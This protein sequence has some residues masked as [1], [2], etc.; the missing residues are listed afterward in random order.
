MSYPAIQGA[1]L[2]T[3]LSIRF[4]LHEDGNMLLLYN[5]Q[6]VFPNRGDFISLAV[7]EGKLEFR[8]DLGY[9]A[10]VIQSKNN[11]TTGHWHT[12]VAERFYRDGSMILDSEPAVKEKAPCCSVGLNLALPLYIGGLP[13]MTADDKKRLGV[14]K[15][16]IGCVSDLSIDDNEIGL[17]NSYI[18]MRSI[19]QCKACLLPCQV[20]P[21]MNNATCEPQGQ[22]GYVCI[23]TSGYT[24]K[25]CEFPLVGPGK[26]R[27]CLNGGLPF[28]P[29]GKVCDCPI[30]YGGTRCESGKL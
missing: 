22:T 9:G 28:P 6:Q 5:G 15:G 7:I 20:K 19:K 1:L 13:N 4:M 12:V 8:F 25:N 21:C 30:G 3:K 27:T 26:N 10:A 23:C 16:L 17:V 14:D 24:G 2:E 11:I 29:T 18:E